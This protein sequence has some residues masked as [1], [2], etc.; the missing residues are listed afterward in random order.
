MEQAGLSVE[1]L[2]LLIKSI[3][4]AKSLGGYSSSYLFCDPVGR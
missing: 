1:D 4:I 3:S 2:P